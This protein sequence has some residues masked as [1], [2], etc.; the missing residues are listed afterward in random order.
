MIIHAKS[1]YMLSHSVM[2]DSATPW[3]VTCQAPL[4]MGFP[5]QEYWS[6]IL[7]PTPVQ[8]DY[9]LLNMGQPEFCCL[10]TLT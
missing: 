10:A 4:S 8:S 1:Y 5:K 9:L 7:F 3:T 6:G 2:S